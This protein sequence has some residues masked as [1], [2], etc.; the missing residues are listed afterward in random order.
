MPTFPASPTTTLRRAAY[1]PRLDRSLRTVERFMRWLGL[2]VLIGAASADLLFHLVPAASGPVFSA[3]FGPAAERAHVAT[4]AGMAITVGA[5]LLRGVRAS[6]ASGRAGSRADAIR[7][8][9]E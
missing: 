5:V 2:G 4:V 3:L 7:T 1:G 6:V 9:H 8:T